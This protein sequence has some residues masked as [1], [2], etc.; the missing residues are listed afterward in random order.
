MGDA[1]HARKPEGSRRGENFEDSVD[2]GG[3]TPALTVMLGGREERMATKKSPSKKA[4]TE[5]VPEK[6]AAKKTA[7]KKTAAPKVADVPSPVAA[8][9]SSAEPTKAAG[10]KAEKAKPTHHD[11]AVQAYLLWERDG[12]KHGHHVDYWHKAEKELQG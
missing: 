9:P 1:R 11:I 12:K 7:A 6:T 5:A 10:H 8:H 3:A 4:V 2:T